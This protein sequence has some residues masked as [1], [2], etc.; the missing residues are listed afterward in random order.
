VQ[1]FWPPSRS[2]PPI[3]SIRAVGI[4]IRGN[5]WRLD[6]FRC[7]YSTFP[8]TMHVSQPPPKSWVA[9]L[10]SKNKR[11]SH[12]SGEDLV[13]AVALSALTTG[14]GTAGGNNQRCEVF[15]NSTILY[16]SVQCRQY[17]LQSRLSSQA[18]SSQPTRYGQCVPSYCR[19]APSTSTIHAKLDSLPNT[20]SHQ[21]TPSL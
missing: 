2:R 6:T 10:L 14:T 18:T 5:G 21:L 15:A 17:R 4:W 19:G 13:V 1:C 8:L 20:Y 12:G 9:E 11:D 7:R 16:N 3:L